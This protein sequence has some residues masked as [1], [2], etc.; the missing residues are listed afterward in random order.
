MEVLCT[1]VR[2][3]YAQ[4][5]AVKEPWKLEDYLEDRPMFSRSIEVSL[6]PTLSLK[7]LELIALCNHG[8]FAGQ[9]LPTEQRLD[10]GVYHIIRA[11]DR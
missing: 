10:A 5:Y 2:P 3:L 6:F 7:A 11:R 1:F 9:L 8:I 4:W